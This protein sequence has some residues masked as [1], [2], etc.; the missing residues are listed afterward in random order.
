[1]KRTRAIA[2]AASTLALVAAVAAWNRPPS[3]GMISG[4]VDAKSF[5]AMTFGP[6][7]VLFLADND[8]EAV[9]A[10]EIADAGKSSAK[11]EM[12]GID[13]KIA[14]A[15]GTTADQIAIADMAVHP[16][17]HNIY[18]TVTRGKG[19]DAR[20][21][22][23]RVTSDA[24]QPISVV[25]LDNIKHSITKIDNAPA[26]TGGVGGGARDPHRSTITDLAFVDGNLW[27]AGL[28]NEQFSSAFRRVAFPFTS[29]KEATTTLQIYHVSHRR[30]ETQAP[31]MTFAPTKINGTLYMLA[32]YTC[33]PIVAFAA[34]DLKNGQAVTGRTVAELGAGNQP[35]DIISYTLNGKGYVLVAN[36]THPMMKLSSDEIAGAPALTTPDVV[37]VART[38]VSAPGAV[39]QLADLDEQNV[40]VIQ[41]GA[42]GGFDLKTIAKSSF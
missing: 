1:M 16:M 15:L 13:A 25:S 3:N 38:N 23:V 14:Q 24:A 20:P 17:S 35:A 2:V 9:Y 37:G 11:V 32:A 40:V 30:S 19:A 22:L 26:S 31:V 7:N 6:G 42:S 29:A 21:V 33:T 34:S 5:G 41:K 18:V 4:P 39:V 36:R 27:I 8:A 12:A 10:L 28:S